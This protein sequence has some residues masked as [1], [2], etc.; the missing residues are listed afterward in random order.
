MYK[1]ELDHKNSL[2]ESRLDF[3]SNTL[4]DLILSNSQM[5]IKNDL[6]YR[7]KSNNVIVK[8]SVKGKNYE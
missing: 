7:L 5:L 4:I 6:P 3:I 2:A 1:K 8:D